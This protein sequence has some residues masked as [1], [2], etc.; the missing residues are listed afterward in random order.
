MVFAE[1]ER[2][3]VPKLH[4]LM[5]HLEGLQLELDGFSFS[6]SSQMDRSQPKRLDDGDSMICLLTLPNK[7]TSKNSI[8]G[9]A[10]HQTIG[11][12]PSS[13]TETPL[14]KLIR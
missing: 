10:F 13:P 9:T 14:V 1:H 11:G 6:Q 2:C 8:L 12:L 4:T 3:H 7:N 5:H